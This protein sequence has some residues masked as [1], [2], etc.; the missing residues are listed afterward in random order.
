MMEALESCRCNMVGIKLPP[1]PPPGDNLLR[2]LN[3][4]FS[5]G[6]GGDRGGS[7]FEFVLSKLFDINLVKEPRFNESFRSRFG[8][9]GIADDVEPVGEVTSGMGPEVASME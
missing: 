2:N 4:L 8:G 6:D 1:V 9:F 7:F 5:L 3:I